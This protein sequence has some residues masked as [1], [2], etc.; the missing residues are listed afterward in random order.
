MIF[1]GRFVLFSIP[2]NGTEP[3]WL[4]DRFARSRLPTSSI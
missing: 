2:E 4:Q 3:G 1:V